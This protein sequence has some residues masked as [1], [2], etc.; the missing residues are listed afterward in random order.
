M[1]FF[2]NSEFILNVILKIT[3]AL[4]RFLGKK[5]L[6]P[7]DNLLKNIG[8]SN[9]FNAK[10]GMPVYRQTAP[11]PSSA[12]QS[13]GKPLQRQARHAGLQA[14]RSS[15]KLGMPVYRQTAP[16]PSSA[17]RCT[18][19]PLQRQARHASL[20]VNRSIY[21]EQFETNYFFGQF[22]SKLIKFDFLSFAQ[23]FSV[24]FFTHINIIGVI[25]F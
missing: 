16:A 3:E 12:C 4:F 14:N 7:C 11:A 9:R 5:L 13:T 15:V 2:Q 10:L 19:K 21:M 18:G 1:H 6:T 20:Q 24:P 17:C 23:Y 8:F 22:I 25:A